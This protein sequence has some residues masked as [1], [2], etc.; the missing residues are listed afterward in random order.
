[1]FSILSVE[2]KIY[3]KLPDMDFIVQDGVYWSFYI[4]SQLPFLLTEY[5]KC[6]KSL[7]P[8]ISVS[9]FTF[10]IRDSIICKRFFYSG[11]Y[12]S[13]LN[14]HRILPTSIRNIL[15]ENMKSYVDRGFRIRW[16]YHC[17]GVRLP[18][19]D[20]CVLWVV[21]RNAVSPNIREMWSNGFRPHG[22]IMSLWSK[23][24]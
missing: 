9:C 7:I 3:S 20:P 23:M 21:I 18:K 2:Y 8:T 13:H 11:S 14:Y 17:R 22:R 24:C 10:I 19:E 15:I 12:A 4:I 1:M 5:K 16:L 6:P